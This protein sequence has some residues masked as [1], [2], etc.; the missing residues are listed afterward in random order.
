MHDH[1]F[2]LHFSLRG[3]DMNYRRVNFTLYIFYHRSI[4]YLYQNNGPSRKL[5]PSINAKSFPYIF[6]ESGLD[7]LSTHPINYG[8]HENTMLKIHVDILEFIYNA[9]ERI[10]H[11]SPSLKGY[12]CRGPAARACT[13]E[14]RVGHST[15]H[16]TM[17]RTSGENHPHCRW[18]QPPPFVRSFPIKALSG[19]GAADEILACGALDRRFW[20]YRTRWIDFD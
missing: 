3:M 10:V 4:Y 13:K 9:L 17:G 19:S 1:G 5:H 8:H 16:R 18:P 12:C 2:L 15:W 7:F 6:F 20:I 14:S 11:V